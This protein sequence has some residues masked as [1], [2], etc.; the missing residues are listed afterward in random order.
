MFSLQN[1]VDLRRNLASTEHRSWMVTVKL[2]NA[3]PEVVSSLEM[4][5]GHWWNFTKQHRKRS[6]GW[7]GPRFYCAPESECFSWWYHLLSEHSGLKI[8]W[9][10][11]YSL[12]TRFSTTRLMLRSVSWSSF[13][14][15]FWFSLSQY[16]FIGCS[17]NQ[18]RDGA[19]LSPQLGGASYWH[20]L[21]LDNLRPTDL[22]WEQQDPD[23]NTLDLLRTWSN[24]P[25]TR[26][27]TAPPNSLLAFV[28]GFSTGCE[29][30]QSSHCGRQPV[31]QRVNKWKGAGR[32]MKRWR[33]MESFHAV[34]SGVTQSCNYQ[35]V[36]FEIH[37]AEAALV[38]VESA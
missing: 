4:Y 19:I 33:D 36:S 22:P 11:P 13:A 29:R 26:L 32:A 16:G 15:G 8:Q 18:G 20:L 34:P 3:F 25:F 28:F 23:S 1:A 17:L 12:E 35:V 9:I 31:W 2:C 38:E 6:R 37:V 30:R 7:W 21:R 14:K 24:L 5:P 10:C 27:S